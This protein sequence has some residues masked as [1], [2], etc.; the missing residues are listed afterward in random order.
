MRECQ[1]E[2]HG[3]SVMVDRQSDGGGY[4]GGAVIADTQDGNIMVEMLGGITRIYQHCILRG[5][6]IKVA[7]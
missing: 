5:W 6:P 1:T 3:G 7:M 4:Q 2:E